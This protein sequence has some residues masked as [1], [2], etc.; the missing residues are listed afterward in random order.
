M[1]VIA[2]V[3]SPSAGVSSLAAALADRLPDH[4]VVEASLAPDAV[5]VVASAVAPLADSDVDLIERAAAGTDLVIGAV[6]KI[7]AHRGWRDVQ[8][9]DRALLARRDE[10]YQKVPWVGV[11]AAPDLGEP[12]VDELV[13]T[14]VARLAKP[15]RLPR[16]RQASRSMDAIAVRGGIQRARLTLTYFV[17]RRCAEIGA[18][19]RA[20]AAEL[21]RGGVARFGD[22]V[23]D[24]V[25]D[26]GAE[27]DVVIDEA[28]DRAIGEFA[29]TPLTLTPRTLTPARASAGPPPQLPLPRPSSRRLETRLMLVLGGGF[30]LGVA[31]TLGRLTTALGPGSDLIGLVVGGVVGLLLT[32]WVVGIRGVLHDRALMDRWVGEVIATLRSGGEETVARRML[33]AEIAFTVELRA[34]NSELR[35]HNRW[36][37]S[38]ENH[39]KRR[40]SASESFL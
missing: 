39:G 33:D 18:D 16:A 4:T 31:L 9:A 34:N 15:D 1:S 40:N 37:R 24:A 32:I 28:V 7:D 2:V 8:A 11:A 29:L 19:L 13:R 23:R 12:D 6:S 10:R 36:P 25:A 3:G 14:L 21:P 17:R 35:T 20:E 27:L 38:T 22:G 26:F 5:V 30:G